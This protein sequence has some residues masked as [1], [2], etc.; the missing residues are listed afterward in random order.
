MN[1][2][3]DSGEPDVSGFG[4]HR[5]ASTAQ[6]SDLVAA[7]AAPGGSLAE[8]WLED[9]EQLVAAAAVPGLDTQLQSTL[10]LSD[11]DYQSMVSLARQLLPAERLSLVSVPTSTTDLH[12]GALEPAPDATPIV[13]AVAA[14]V[15]PPSVNLIARMP[16]IRNQ[17]SRGTCVAFTMTAMNEF[18]LRRSDVQEDL[19]EQH[20]YAETKLIDGSPACGTFQSKAA[21]VLRQ[22]GEC[23]ESVW[24]YNP[25]PPCN[26]NG[27]QPR[28]ARADGAN[29]RLNSHAV[30]TN[31]VNAYKAELAE[32]NPVGLSIPV[33]AS[34][35]ASAET[36]RSG[37]IT[38]RIG[39][40]N[41]TGGHALL[42]VGYQ[43]T[44]ESPGGGYFLVRNSWSTNWAYESP[45]GAGYGTIPYQYITDLAWE[46]FAADMPARD[47]VIAEEVT[48][49]ASSVVINVG[50][51]IT[52]TVNAR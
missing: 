44:S 19:S 24:P 11:D 20:L 27:I 10:A 41:R 23:R 22:R 12:L 46:A 49:T 34:W 31:D 47:A 33:Y 13:T 37:R 28:Q 18:F 17:A 40:E 48:R 16:P 43:D 38:M 15:A 4:G 3:G 26:N 29:Y 32:G 45:Y 2:D 35:H 1:G 25:N 50:P 36:R 14:G 30:P 6:E 5:M 9:A 52:I 7:A 39:N 8:L 42:V 51:D 21:S